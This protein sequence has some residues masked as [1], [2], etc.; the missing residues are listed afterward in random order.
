MSSD[1]RRARSR[2]AA[3]VRNHPDADH[4]P[5]RRDLAAANLEAYVAKTVAAAPPLTSEQLDRIA[6][7]LRPGGEA[8]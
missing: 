1:I 7:L 5:L 6:G 3:N 4:A 8:A 2:L